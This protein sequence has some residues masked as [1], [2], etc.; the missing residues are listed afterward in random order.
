MG[1]RVKDEKKWPQGKIPYLFTAEMLKDEHKRFRKLIKECMAQWEEYLNEGKFY[2][3]FVERTNEER[4]VQISPT[5]SGSTSSGEIGVPT[6]RNYSNFTILTKRTVDND[7]QMVIN[8]KMSIPHELGHVL[9]LVH[10]QQRSRPLIEK[11]KAIAGTGD[12][13]NTE[14]P[15]KAR[16]YYVGTQF[17]TKE[18]MFASWDRKYVPVGDY[19][20][21][22]IMHYPSAAGWAWN[23]A[24]YQGENGPAAAI[25]ALNYPSAA[26][27]IAKTWAP[28]L[29]DIAALQELY[30]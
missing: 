10:E 21:D 25:A 30:R 13:A 4:Y 3:Q 17:M 6:E 20:L 14:D 2:V 15:T 11:G 9:G 24:P 29:G 12:E 18:L 19:D 22:S 1:Y 26:Q 28:S 27:V 8:P 7:T 23:Y 16:L 5:D